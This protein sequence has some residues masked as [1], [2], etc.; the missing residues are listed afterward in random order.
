MYGYDLFR[1]ISDD[2]NS[3]RDKLWQLKDHYEKG[4]SA[5]KISVDRKKQSKSSIN[6]GRSTSLPCNKINA[7]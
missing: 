3:E 6:T 5:E 4:S 1:L 7:S 2:P